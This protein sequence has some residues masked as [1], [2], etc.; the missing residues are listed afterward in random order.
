MKISRFTK[1]VKVDNQT[2]ILYNTFSRQYIELLPKT[3][4]QILSFLDEVNKG[5]YSQE[6]ITLFSE[7]VNKHI[8]VSE[9]TDELEQIRKA[10]YNAC[11]KRNKF[12]IVI[13]T[14]NRC[15]FRCTYCT[16]DHLGKNLEENTIKQV[17]ELIERI[18][19]EV[20]E[21]E[22]NWFGGEPLLQ[23]SDIVTILKQVNKI[24]KRNHCRC[25]S[26]MVT[27]GFLLDEEKIKELHQLNV[28]QMQITVDGNRKI[29]DKH[30]VLVNGAGTYDVILKNICLA[31]ET[32]ILVTLRVNIDKST[33]LDILDEIPVAQRKN[34]MVSIANLFQ[35]KE[36]VSTYKMAKIAIEKGYRYQG[37]YNSYAQ[38]IANKKNSLY[39]DADGSILLCSN[40]CTQEPAIGMLEG[41][42]QIVYCDL[43]KREEL[44]NH[45]ILENP[46]CRDCVELPLCVGRCQYGR[47][48]HSEKCFGKRFDALT[49]VERAKMDYYY[50]KIK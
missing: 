6:E 11:H 48:N 38:C 12:E 15:N 44:Q 40:T 37:R 20:D 19:Q 17:I 14:T 35:N 24:C 5:V 7:M 36:K 43:K 45:S 32:G 25:S 9:E 8:I 10:E 29:H 30:R 50:D 33:T 3:K 23:Y 16:Q 34:V 39:I 41:Q 13:Y 4:D 49:L 28:R 22:L 47:K 42:G 21:I 2:S 46:K 26:N 27:N 31:L 1:I 18:S